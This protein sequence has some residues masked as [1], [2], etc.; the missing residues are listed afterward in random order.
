MPPKRQRPAEVRRVCFV[1]GTRAEFGLMDSTLRAIKKSRKLQLQLI[2]TGTHTHASRGNTVTEILRGWKI[3]RVVDW[4]D[5]SDA[6][7]IARETGRVSSELVDAFEQLRSD[8]VLVVGDRVEAFAAASAAHLSGRIVAHVH[9]G[10][11][12]LGQTDDAIRHAITKLAHIHFAATPGSVQRISRLGEDAFRIHHVGAPGTDGIAREAASKR[13]MKAMGIEGSFALFLLH[14]TDSDER[15][16]VKRTEMLLK[17]VRASE[18]AQVVC[19]LPNNDPGAAGIEQTLRDAAGRQDVRL[20]THARREQFLGLLRDC[21]LLVGNSSAGI[22][23][24]GAFGTPVVNVGPRQAGRERGGNVFQAEWTT[25]SIRRAIDRALERGRKLVADN[26]YGST[27]SGA[28]IARTLAS[29][30]LTEQLRR[31]LIRY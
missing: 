31:K 13:A 28:R 22:I 7:T 16:E 24:A 27:G 30:R 4:K 3:D 8:I 1:T 6:I 26:P 25:P 10:D 18:L 17:A 23:E 19:L 2:V 9:G 15:A 12:A 29:V 11:R 5:S 21:R 20:L 14:P